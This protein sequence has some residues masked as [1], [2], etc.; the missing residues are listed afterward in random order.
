MPEGQTVVSDPAGA[1]A[2]AIT[3]TGAGQVSTAPNGT[4]ETSSGQAASQVQGATAEDNFTSIDPKTLTPELQAV[5]KS[6]L[7]DYTKKTMAVADREKQL[8]SALKKAAEYD[9]LTSSQQ[10]KET[11]AEMS[12]REKTDFKEQK[13]EME[14]SLGEKISDEEFNAAFQTKDGFLNLLKKV[15]DESRMKDQ[16]EISELKQKVG[17]SEAS[18]I[19]DAV[20]LEKGKDGQFIRPDF[21]DMEE[22]ISGYLRLN[23][24]QNPKDF[25]QSVTNAY[26]WAKGYTQKFYEKGRAEALKV[27]TQK[28]QNSSQP[29]T[30]SS[31]EAYA[32]PDPKTLDAHEAVALA[33]K[34]QRVPRNF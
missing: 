32:G 1:V 17:T 12:R 5:H 22:L 9:K 13:A 15:A 26:D 8:E 30:L 21:Y 33:R 20:S 11:W 3:Q 7:G 28:V 6:M 34:G 25:Q 27:I 16:K 10:F 23:V 4:A 24:S 2:T 31:K 29:P 18:N 19:I 14:K